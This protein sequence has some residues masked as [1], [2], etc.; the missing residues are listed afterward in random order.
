MK[1]I[2]QSLEK[3]LAALEKFG[4]DSVKLESLQEFLQLELVYCLGA[5]EKSSLSK[6]ETEY[7]AQKAITIGGKGLAEQNSAHRYFQAVARLRSAE[8]LSSGQ[9]SEEFLIDLDSLH[10]LET[11]P[12]QK[13]AKYSYKVPYVLT[14]YIEW[15]SQQTGTPVEIAVEAAIKL[16]QASV[17]EEAY[18]RTILLLINFLLLKSKYPLIFIQEEDVPSYLVECTQLRSGGAGT[19]FASIILRA[20]DASLD[21]CLERVI[22]KDASNKA[23]L[24]KIGELAKL[25]NETVPTIRHWTKQGLLA[26]AGHSPGGYQLYERSMAEVV[27]KIRYLQKEKRMSVR[28]IG[29]R[30]RDY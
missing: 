29:E 21:M 23:D 8:V 16:L 5:L 2:T 26:V 27:L 19:T 3:K 13:L 11:A 7:V 9:V 18:P 28:E 30:V 1:N 15:L 22:E 10:F 17:F 25:T 20:V 6:A 4:L 12:D 24:L 14:E